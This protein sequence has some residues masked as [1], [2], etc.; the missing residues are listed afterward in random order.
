MFL[1]E[2]DTRSSRE[3]IG[4]NFWSHF[5]H[6]SHVTI[7]FYLCT[8]VGLELAQKIPFCW[9]FESGET[10]GYTTGWWFGTWISW[11]S[12]YWECHNP[13][14]RTHIF[15]RG[16]YTTNQ[17][18]MNDEPLSFSYFQRKPPDRCW[19]WCCWWSTCPCTIHRRK[20]EPFLQKP[21]I[22][23]GPQILTP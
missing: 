8:S 19:G 6:E 1:N 12:I 20:L 3:R 16:R 22:F 15:Q 21:F 2:A 4:V 13:N 14:S 17:T 11:L 9:V 10:D 18:M 7:T 23:L 5:R